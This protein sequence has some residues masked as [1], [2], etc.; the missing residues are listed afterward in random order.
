[1][2]TRLQSSQSERVSELRYRRLFESAA[3]GVLIVDFATRLITD[4]NPFIADLLHLHRENLCGLELWETGLLESKQASDSLFRE[5]EQNGGAIHRLARIESKPGTWVE[6][7]MIVKR[8]RE[9]G[10][11]VVQ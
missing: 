3:D 11:Q 9:D 7:E 2:E 10:R 6:V 1:M 5:L 8:Y 4:A